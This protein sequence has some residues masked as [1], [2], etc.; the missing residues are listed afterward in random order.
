MIYGLFS[1][2]MYRINYRCSSRLTPIAVDRKRILFSVQFFFY[3]ALVIYANDLLE[4][5]VLEMQ[6]AS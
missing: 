6:I 1:E 5:M 2:K 3:N 4:G